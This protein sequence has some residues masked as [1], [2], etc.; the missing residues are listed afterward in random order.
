MAQR[1]YDYLEVTG[2]ANQETTRTFLTST[3]EEPKRILE[4]WAYESTP[5]RNNDAILRVYVE[6]ER[7][8]ELPIRAFLDQA[9]TPTYPQ[10]AGKI[11][12][13][14]ELP[15]GQ[16]LIVGHLSGSNPSNV[17]FVA[18]YEIGK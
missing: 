15:V 16:S 14:I 9:A 6:R 7:V 18:V 2:A 13:E 4:L 5:A 3:E 8:V 17:V 11:P 1:F 10:G 12:L